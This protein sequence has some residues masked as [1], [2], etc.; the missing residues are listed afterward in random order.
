MRRIVPAGLFA[1]LPALR[2][3][4]LAGS[5]ARM[6]PGAFAGLERLEVLTLHHSRIEDLPAGIFDGLSSLKALNLDFNSLRDL[7]DGIFSD[8]T[9]LVAVRM[10]NNWRELPDGLFEGMPDLRYV[11]ISDG[12]DTTTALRRVPDRWFHGLGAPLIHFDFATKRHTPVLEV[13]LEALGPGR[14]RA[15][16]PSGATLD[17]VLPVSAVNGTIAGG[18]TTLTIPAGALASRELEVTRNAGTTAAVT[19]N[20]GGLPPL[21]VQTDNLD[22]FE[23]YGLQSIIGRG[24]YG[25]K[26]AKAGHLPLTVIANTG[27]P[28][29]TLEVAQA[30]IAEDGGATAVTATLPAVAD[31]AADEIRFTVS[32]VAVAPATPADYTLSTPALTIAAGARDSTGTVTIAAVNNDRYTGN[33]TVRLAAAVTAG[34]AAVPAVQTVTITEDEPTP[35]VALELSV[36]SIDEEGGEAQVS[37]ALSGPPGAPVVITVTVEPVPPAEPADFLHSGNT[38]TIAPGATS[39]TGTVTITAVDDPADRPDK[40]LQVGAEAAGL[41]GLSAPAART[42]TIVDRD[43][44]PVARLV[45]DPPAITEAGGRSTVTALLSHASSEPSVLEVQAVATTRDAKFR[46]SGSTLTF[47]ARQTESAGAV[48]ITAIDDSR[49]HLAP[50]TV[51]VR[52]S[53]RSGPATAPEAVTLTIEED[54]LAPPIVNALQLV[55]TPPRISENGGQSVVTARLD[56]ALNDA[57]TITVA[58][59]PV[60]PTRMRDFTRSGTA[61]TIAA[62]A[63]VSTGSVSITALDNTD[64][65]WDKIVTVTATAASGATTA[66]TEHSLTIEED[67]PRPVVSLG[68]DTDTISEKDGVTEIRARLDGV[69]RKDTYLEV[70]VEPV[71]PARRHFDYSVTGYDWQVIRRGETE[72]GRIGFSD[73]DPV[74][75]WAIDDISYTGARQV[76]VIGR[77]D[78]NRSLPWL[79]DPAPRI[80]TITEDDSQAPADGI[81]DRTQEVRTAIIT[82]VVRMEEQGQAPQPTCGEVTAAQLAKMTQLWVNGERAE[83][84]LVPGDFDGLPNLRNVDIDGY[85]RDTSFADYSK[86]IVYNSLTHIHPRLFTGALDKLRILNIKRFDTIRIPAELVA[87]L[88]NLEHLF[89]DRNRV[90]SEFPGGMLANAPNLRSFHFT[91]G[92]LRTLPSGFFQAATALRSISLH[93]NALRSL[94]EGIF[95]GLPDLRTIDLSDTKLLSLP[96]RV[97]AGLPGLRE[98]KVTSPRIPNSAQP[99]SPF[100]RLPEAAFEGL[101]AALQELVLDR[102]SLEVSLRSAGP[103]RFR[104]VAPSGAPFDIELPVSVTNG[105][106]DPTS[107]TIPA[108]AL[109]SAALTVTRTAG[110][111][112]AVTVDIGDLPGLPSGHRG[113]DLIK[114]AVPLTVIGADGAP[115]ATLELSAASIPEDGG[116]SGVTARLS[117]PATGEVRLAV[118]VSPVA[119]ATH[120]DFVASA[121][122]VLTIAA[123]ATGSANTVTVTARDNGHYAGRRTLEI[124][125]AVTAGSAAVPA[126]VTLEIAEDDPAPPPIVLQLSEDSIAEAGGSALV[127]AALHGDA[128][129]VPVTLT[130]SVTPESPAD[131]GDYTQVG[132]KLT[133][134]TGQTQSTGTVRIEAEDD[135]VHAPDRRLRIGAALSGA[136]G[137]A[138][139]REQTLTIVENES[140]PAV[141]LALSDAWVGENGGRATVTATL[142]PASGV[143]TTVT[144]TAVPVEPAVA[145]DIVQQ[146][147]LL[148]FAPATTRSTG[149]VRI[150]AVDN[151]TDAPNRQVDIRATAQ[152]AWGVH[153]PHPVVLEIGDDDPPPVVSLR[154]AP[155][156][157]GERSGAAAVTAALDRPT[158]GQLTL[159]VA[160][161][162]V[163]PALATEFTQ[164]GTSLTIAAGHTVS[165]GTVAIAAADDELYVGAK[166]VRVTAEVA[167]Q[168]DVAAPEPVTL[169]IEED[170]AGPV[171]A[172]VL[173][174]AEVS[175]EAATATVTATIDP[176]V[177]EPFTITVEAVPAAPAAA[178]DFTLSTNRVLSIGAGDAASTGT[179]TITTAGNS[180]AAPAKTVRVTGKVLGARGLAPPDQVLTIV[181][182]E[183]VP[184]AVLVLSPAIIGED[185]ATATVTATLD[186]RAGVDTVLRVTAAPV[187]PAA[188]SDFRQH[189]TTLTIPAGTNASTGEVTITARDNDVDAPDRSVTVSA[190]IAAG[191]ATPPAARPLAIENDEGTPVAQLLLS[192]APIS[193]DEG[194]ST[195]TARLGHPSSE[196]TTV[197]VTAAAGDRA[198]ADDFAVSANRVLSIAAGA[199]V[200][201]GEVTIA[202]VDDSRFRPDRSVTI[203]GTASNA[204]GVTGPAERTLAIEEDELP[205]VVTLQLSAARIAEA[206]TDAAVVTVRLAH[207]VDR[208]T[209]YTVAAA[210]VPPAYGE[211]ILSANRVL[212]V[213]AGDTASTGTV[214]VTAV[215]NTTDAPDSS[216]RVT[217]AVGGFSGLPAPAPV[218]LTVTDDDDAPR[219]TLQRS[220][221]SIGEAGGAARI[222]ATLAHPSSAE[223]TVRVTAEAVAPATPDDFRQD[224]TLL[225]VAAGDTASTGTVTVTA[226]DNDIDAPPGRVFVWATVS[227]AHGV[228]HDPEPVP[229][230]IE[231]DEDTPAA[232]LVLSPASIDEG[233]GLSTVTALLDHPSSEAT[234]V[235]VASAPAG[236]GWYR[237]EG[238]TLTIAAGARASTGTVRI[239]AVDDQ[240]YEPGRTVTVTGSAANGHGVSGPEARTLAIEENEPVPVVTLHLSHGQINEHGGAAT[241][242]ASLDRYVHVQTTYEVSARAVARG[243]PGGFTLSANRMLTI[244]ARQR[245]STGAVTITAAADDIDAPNRE[246]RVTAAVAGLALAA[247]AAR[248]LTIADDDDAPVV[249]LTLSPGAIGERR[250]EARVE[251]SLQHPSSAPTTVHVAAAPVAP[252]EQ[253]D[254]RQRGTTLTIP[255]G[256][257]ASTGAVTI[258]SVDNDV[259]A[260]DSSVEV[261]ATAFNRQGVAAAPS[262]VTL[263]IVD[264]DAAPLVRLLLTPRRIG[265]SGGSSRVTAWVRHPSSED[266]TVTVAANAVGAAGEP[267]YELSGATTLTIPAGARTST[268]NVTITA[269]DNTLYGADRFVTVS[270]DA[271]NTQGISDPA[272]ATLTIEDNE[273]VPVVA[274]HLSTHQAPGGAVTIGEN[275]GQAPVTVSID[276]PFDRDTTYTVTVA[277]VPPA[278]AGDFTLTAP[279]VLTID[280]G[281][282]NGTGTLTVTAVNNDTDAPDKE[283]R[284]TA[285]V[286]GFA[287][288]PAPEARTLTIEDDEDT[289]SVTM[290]LSLA[291]LDERGGVAA[292]TARLDH[293]SSEDTRLLLEVKPDPPAAAAD[294]RLARTALI[295]PAG[296]RVS[297]ELLVEA[298]DNDVDAPRKTM[299]IAAAAHNLHG[300]AGDPAPVSLAVTDDE[301][302]PAVS[303]TLSPAK[304]VEN[305]GK[306]TVT[307]MLDHPSSEDTTV[308]VGSDPPSATWFARSGTELTIAAGR[309]TSTGVVHITAVN[310]AQDAADRTVTV[311]GSAANEHGVAGDPSALVLTIQDDE[312]TPTVYLDLA[313]EFISERGGESTVSARLDHTSSTE[314]VV[315]VAAAPAG[316]AWYTQ[317]GTRL[318]IAAGAGTSTGTVKIAAL[319]NHEDGPN[320]TVTLSASVASGSAMPERRPA[321]L[322]I[323][324][325]E[326]TPTVWLDLAAAAIP[327]GGSTTVTARLSATSSAGVSMRIAYDRDLRLSANPVLRI[328]AGQVASSGSV[329]I[330]APNDAVH[331]EDR[332]IVLR[333]TLFSA[334]GGIVAPAP[335]T[336]TIIEHDP[337]PGV[338][339]E[340]SEADIPEN[341]GETTVTARLD[342]LSTKD[343]AV[344]VAAEAGGA[345]R[346]F[347]QH[348]TVLTIS[349]GST[350]SRGRVRITAL[351]NNV[352]DTGRT[353]RVTGAAANALGVT[354][355]RDLTLTIR[356]DD[357][358][359]TVA[360]ALTRDTLHES[361]SGTEASTI[362]A[363]MSGPSEETVVLTVS[364]RLAAALTGRSRFTQTGTTLTIPAGQTHSNGRVTIT[365]VNDSSEERDKTVLVSATATGGLGVA[366]PAEQALTIVD[367]DEEPAIT[368]H[369]EDE[370]LDEGHSTRVWATITHPWPNLLIVVIS[371]AGWPFEM[372]HEK[373]VCG[374]TIRPGQ[375]ISCH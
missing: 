32:A 238:S 210:P 115:A 214:T 242:T 344:T 177:S 18:A 285:A 92:A 325:D 137:V 353:V 358:T 276:R 43:G 39:G 282:T 302:A 304:I 206:G 332:Q 321:R 105:S 58:A 290:A 312:N 245:N 167:G 346:Y 173:A 317:T 31:P 76:R 253:R 135:R 286:G 65:A 6:E 236:A 180:L 48:T 77:I 247:P 288:V 50:R 278:V 193:E 28:R 330:T 157:I 369:I 334:A 2:E 361:K 262:P 59:A 79:Q 257:T 338:T 164:S 72:I 274:L 248:T 170:E 19:V 301:N 273:R 367:D 250:N 315:S 37:A 281:A 311:S 88:P 129:G 140:T 208:V 20:I 163:P 143:A 255:A 362:T 372:E 134:A 34:T 189:G 98:V 8:L 17:I 12:F 154:A 196:P 308:S 132:T 87:D 345:G 194:V 4:D 297:G 371:T 333:P 309:R 187:A 197:T 75:V 119:P 161:E 295:V 183:P 219:V 84:P 21:P 375:G 303:L 148:T 158:A 91:R 52:A 354:H 323:A 314:T 184:N 11:K 141:T 174:P 116:A 15:L 35:E 195:V 216:V 133:I 243:V 42:L 175:E 83:M 350:W 256:A 335:V 124:A 47:A 166:Q 275:G 235:T 162:A 283:V 296:A 326:G 126:P 322:T 147:T 110:T 155:N 13:S 339:L 104:A 152:N 176:P 205:P 138:A 128:L 259:D 336:L 145:G 356:D 118:T 305:G 244:A 280:A 365:P 363:T 374:S 291:Q 263:A 188:A 313:P 7:P 229:I 78:H 221:A 217:A 80:I 224:G 71:P 264:D 120:D 237:Q 292:L 327:E 289:P 211:V 156:P 300:I 16:A 215:D 114:V 364:S 213:A 73:L 200:S 357:P 181:D 23:V 25:Y 233:G 360:L 153:H 254:F 251:A 62:G 56:T 212:T 272:P 165:A 97:F 131:A 220:P 94:P 70:T 127:T 343:T 54:D 123:G 30:T 26:L 139:P 178:T 349:A 267:Y 293:P 222:G 159:A 299:T 51:D 1:G 121:D 36:D 328:A 319:D 331:G 113:Y 270:G 86:R 347:A 14:F 69:V 93:K 3:L 226:V 230:E 373:G 348:G 53:T 29:V 82:Q 316:A 49:F 66:R 182:D 227:N 287:G 168:D 111:T 90:A 103:G 218:R 298:V 310:N 144:V 239:A 122:R 199:R 171:V 146:G 202:A 136:F 10:L 337:V 266:T 33:R 160:A 203:A 294:L 41:P 225:V 61:L 81:C 22:F 324:D 265:E 241:V 85:W 207:A 366:P 57:T 95:A 246:L 340:L 359:P 151:D 5:A 27:A 261:S 198:T 223:T 101:S 240:Q 320:R 44:P 64:Y 306:S 150:D 74:K 179:V 60:R 100:T 40:L 268:G 368:L 341:G 107:L 108:G 142:L 112:A 342:R 55:L 46:R 249:T 109:E 260:P 99:E 329:T 192:P 307:A 209:T 96:R 24:H 271:A 284:V 228:G 318:T 231:D 252:A 172:L 102:V 234:E 279:T 89:M 201:T 258:S 38:L 117:A 67:D 277:P 186:Q 130:V 191:H 45:L 269:K 125:A 68:L 232:R 204:R 9:S 63:T 370:E 351:D 106:I 149:T 185:G 352:D 169:T 355:P 190:D